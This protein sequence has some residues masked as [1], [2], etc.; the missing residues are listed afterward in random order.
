MI[1]SKEY[2]EKNSVVIFTDEEHGML[3]RMV[4]DMERH[5]GYDTEKMA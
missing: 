5:N 4:I 1:I 2:G 3:K